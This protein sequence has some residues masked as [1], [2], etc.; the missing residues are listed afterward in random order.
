MAI[1]DEYRKE[2]RRIQQFINRAEKRGYQFDFEM[3]EIPKKVTRASVNRLKAITPEKLYKK[4]VYGGEAT[5]GEIVSGVE[6]RKQERVL[7]GKRAS[8][9]RILKTEYDDGPDDQYVIDTKPV[10]KKHDKDKITGFQ[11]IYEGKENFYDEVVLSTFY[12][13]LGSMANA[14]MHNLMKAFM[15]GLI[16]QKGKAAVARAIDEA[17]RSGH[18]FTWQV[19]YKDE[20]FNE[21]ISAILDL[22]PDEGAIF[23]DE[24]KDK[25]EIAKSMTETAEIAEAWEDFG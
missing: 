3:P 17:Y 12:G 24:W 7:A 16:Q 22:I 18:P 19:M 9:T 25:L 23:K 8:E 11:R 15:D 14:P 4:S 5:L 21:F 6:G 1:K 13:E 10:P 20:E 2:R